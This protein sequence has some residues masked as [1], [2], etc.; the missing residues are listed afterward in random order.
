MA[1]ETTTLSAQR[2]DSSI[3]NGGK[4]AYRQGL[5]AGVVY[6]NGVEPF[7]VQADPR[8]VA[9]A[10]TTRFGRNAVLNLEVEGETHLCMVKDT[11]FDPVRREI[12]HMDLYVVTPEQTVTLEIPVKP[13]GQAIGQKLGGLLQVTSRTVKVRCAVKDIPEAVTH[14]VGPLQVG[15]QVYVDEMTAPEGC[16][17]VFKN[18]FPVI[19]IASRRGAVRQD[20]AAEATAES[21]E[22]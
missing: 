11:Q 2:R 8:D 18:R 7:T 14:E 9:A 3:R 15:D 12:T 6:G 20:A 5:I 17:L 16:E 21:A 4:K 1:N 13:S 19:R 22:A 10:L